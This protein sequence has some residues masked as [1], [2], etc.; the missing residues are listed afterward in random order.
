MKKELK[1]L[2][3]S[4]FNK[5]NEIENSLLELQN[6]IKKENRPGVVKTNL[7]TVERNEYTIRARKQTLL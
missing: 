4:A 6:S 2:I 1:N 7:I 3:Q 5:L